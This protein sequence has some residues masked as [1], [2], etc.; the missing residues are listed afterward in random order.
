MIEAVN[1]VS[2]NAQMLRAVAEQTSSTQSFAS[3]PTRVQS[4]AISAPYLSPHVDL[5]GGN[6]KPIFIV[7]DSATGDAI[8]QFPTE[9]QIR[10]YQR[11]QEVQ[12]RLQENSQAAANA[13]VDT[14]QQRVDIVEN[15]VQ[16][17]ELRKA[18]REQDAPLPGSTPGKKSQGTSG[19]SEVGTTKSSGS[20][21]LDTAV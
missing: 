6:S 18:V 14:K 11:A 2:S 7:R 12:V 15:S 4:A 19:G 1:A 21:S 9:G 13:Q 3:N 16:Y 17:K 8:R 5:N 10:A 20:N